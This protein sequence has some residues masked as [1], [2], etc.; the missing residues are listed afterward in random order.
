MF[1]WFKK[2]EPTPVIDKYVSRYMYERLDFCMES[3]DFYDLAHALDQSTDEDDF[4]YLSHAAN[5]LEDET[6]RNVMKEQI[7]KRR[8][9]WS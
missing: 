9:G 6:S 1:G 7:L 5:Y 8:M 2:K 4:I 3:V